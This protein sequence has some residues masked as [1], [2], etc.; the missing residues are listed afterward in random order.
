V[1]SREPRIDVEVFS[2]EHC[3]TCR[4]VEGFLRERGIAFTSRDVLDDEAAFEK[5]VERG[6]MST[7]VTRI[8]DEWIAGFDRQAFE[9]L[10]S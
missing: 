9:R 8:G 3:A 5:I 10:L 1:N 6:Y 7:P 4:Q 2:Q